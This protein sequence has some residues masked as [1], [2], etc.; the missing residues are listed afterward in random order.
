[1]FTRW[2]FYTGSNFATLGDIY[3]GAKIKDTLQTTTK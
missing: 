2:Y 3:I 1:M